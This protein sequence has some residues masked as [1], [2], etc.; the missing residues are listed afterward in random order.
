MIEKINKLLAEKEILLNELKEWVKDKS[1]PLEER[2]NAFITVGELIKPDGYYWD[3]KSLNEDDFHA[4]QDKY[5]IFN[6]NRVIEYFEDAT[7]EE[8]N[9]FKEEALGVFKYS[10]E[11]D[12]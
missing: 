3:F 6:V 2:W 12:W 5:K 7:E 10:W 4:D 9:N 11:F 1:I 8:I